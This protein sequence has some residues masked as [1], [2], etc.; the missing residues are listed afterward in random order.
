M[1][2][3]V[4]IRIENG[5]DG[6]NVVTVR[7]SMGAGQAPLIEKE[8]AVQTEGEG[9]L[10]TEPVNI[11]GRLSAKIAGKLLRRYSQAGVSSNE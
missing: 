7:Q 1:I 5:G 8:T 2:M 10:N 4:V 9:I 11:I 3:S 6:Y